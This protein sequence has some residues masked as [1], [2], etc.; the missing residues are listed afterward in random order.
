MISEPYFVPQVDA[1]T[2]SRAMRKRQA[3]LAYVSRTRSSSELPT[4]QV[5]WDARYD[6]TA[7]ENA[8]R[9]FNSVDDYEERTE[10]ILSS[11]DR[12]H[13]YNWWREASGRR[14]AS[15]GS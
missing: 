8:A 10:Q 1:Q 3:V 15:G 14:Q 11:F 13:F 12:D 6:L 9:Q 5:S 2:A 4:L 7:A